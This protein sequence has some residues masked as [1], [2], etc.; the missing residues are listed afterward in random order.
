MTKLSCI[1]LHEGKKEIS[2]FVSKQYCQMATYTLLKK[3][4]KTLYELKP[5]LL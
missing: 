1:S 3:E 2:V 4:G 5:K